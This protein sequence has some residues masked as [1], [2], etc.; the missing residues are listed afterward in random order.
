MGV[1]LLAGCFATGVFAE[2]MT[3]Q[4]EETSALEKQQEEENNAFFDSLKQSEQSPRFQYNAFGRRDPFLSFV[5]P[6]DE[7][8]EK[9]PPLQR[10]SVSEMKL[11][12]VAWGSGRVSAMVQTPDG[13]SYP[14]Q[15]GTRMGTNQG[16]VSQ[17]G[18]ES[19][20]VEEPYINIFGRAA[21]KQVVM[22]LYTKKEK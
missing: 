14:V 12:G 15:R 8:R 22:K 9:M 4:E 17:I 1:V 5:G 21:Q 20:T 3:P 6:D 16:R 7:Q 2:E 13:K 11:I 10:V 19:V 18:K